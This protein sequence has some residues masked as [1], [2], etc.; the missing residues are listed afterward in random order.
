MSGSSA[1]LHL[2]QYAGYRFAEKLYIFLY[3]SQLS[4]WEIYS[5]T[6]SK[7]CSARRRWGSWWSG[8]TLL[9]RLQS[10]TNLNWE[11]S[12][13]PFLQSVSNF[14]CLVGD[15]D[16]LLNFVILFLC[17]HIWFEVSRGLHFVAH[18]SPFRF[19]RFQCR[20]SRIQEHQF[21]SVGCRRAGQ[22]PATLAPLLPEHSRLVKRLD[23]LRDQN[24]MQL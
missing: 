15:Y 10:Y 3:F 16:H 1:K 14:L 19:C 21:Y 13:P 22:N 20:N 2:E 17:V 23:L 9:E 7:A 18:I 8:W 12:S 4:G 24:F 11:R 5:R 6:S